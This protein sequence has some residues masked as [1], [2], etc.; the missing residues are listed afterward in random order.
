MQLLDMNFEI[1]RQC[2]ARLN[3]WEGKLAQER[4]DR[5]ATTREMLERMNYIQKDISRN[6]ERLGEHDV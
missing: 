3:E 1:V 2:L 4:S 5:E 6:K